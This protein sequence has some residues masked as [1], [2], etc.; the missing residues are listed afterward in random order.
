MSRSIWTSCCRRTDGYEVVAEL[1]H[2]FDLMAK[3]PADEALALVLRRVEG[4]SLKK[5]PSG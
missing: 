2:V 4:M 3:L 1:R 5:L